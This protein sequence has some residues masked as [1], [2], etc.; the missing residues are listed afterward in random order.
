MSNCLSL[1]L[2][3]KFRLL[4][5]RSSSKSNLYVADR[6]D[7]EL[8]NSGEWILMLLCCLLFLSFFCK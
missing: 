1:S 8:G 7:E 6:G 5:S 3:T 4:L 2:K